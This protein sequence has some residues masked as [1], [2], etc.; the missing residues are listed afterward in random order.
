[1]KIAT[2]GAGS[3]VWGPTI[4]TDFL[5]NTGLDG[6]ELMLMDVNGET[7]GLVKRHL[8][9]LVA[10]RGLRK[11]IR[12]TT[13]LT[14]ALRDADY[15]LTAISVGGDRIWRY[16]AL[17]P[18]VYGV[19]QPVGDTI[20]P[21]GLMR[22]LR[23]APA[24]LKVGRTMLD[25]ARPGAPLIQLTNP[26]NPLCAALE[27][28]DGLTVYGICHGVDDTEAIF[29]KQLGVPKEQ[30]RIEAAGNNHFIFCTEI[31]VGD[32]V[33]DQERFLELTPRV[34]DTPLREEVFR[35]YGALV[36]NYCRHP[37]EF[38]PGF[39]TLEHEFGR[40]WGVSPIAS[41]IDPM[42]GERQDRARELLEQAIGQPEPIAWRDPTDRRWAGLELNGQG[43]AEAGHSR[44]IVDDFLVALE[45]RGDFFIHLNLRN[46]GAIEGVPDEHNVELPVVFEDGKLRRKPVRFRNE[47]VTREVARVGREQ[48]L[49]AQA[50][51]S[52]D[53]DLLIE[54]LAMDALVP[55]ADV[56]ARLVREMIAFEKDHVDVPLASL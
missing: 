7:L 26:M 55:S 32:E 5:L 39:V 2:I 47:A 35:R 42:R 20:G 49:L 36:A 18:Q 44:E 50:C 46:D 14:E 13:D 15:V 9:R 17:F 10:E 16:D 12:A 29:S 11:T 28:L 4:N 27:S 30:V 43:R 45:N 1:L 21:G 54:A 23:H 24:L 31:R 53:V 3:V 34:F 25:V 22:A 48:Y 56:A 40:R 33:Y 37:I 19:F 41:E 8:E 51:V 52:G 38:M 6:A